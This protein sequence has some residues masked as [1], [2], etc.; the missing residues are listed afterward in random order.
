MTLTNEQN[1]A[2][3]RAVGGIGAVLITALMIWGSSQIVENRQ[4]ISRTKDKIERLERD[5][6]GT[7]DAYEALREKY[8]VMNTQI[9]V[10]RNRGK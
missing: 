7:E 9:Q 1:T 8:S 6:Q 3:W 10:L 2:I 4:D 5:L